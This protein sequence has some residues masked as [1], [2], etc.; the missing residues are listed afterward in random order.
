[1]RNA[2]LSAL[3]NFDA[4]ENKRVSLL[5]QWLSFY[6]KIVVLV[7]YKKQYNSFLKAEFCIIATEAFA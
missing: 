7:Q 2:S 4:E 3:Y 5:S 1:M 6:N